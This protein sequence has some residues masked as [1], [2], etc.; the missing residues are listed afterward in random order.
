MCLWLCHV[1]YCAG[2][3]RGAGARARGARGYAALCRPYERY[4]SESDERQRSAADPD[5][6]ACMRLLRLGIR[7]EVLRM[8]L[9]VKKKELPAGAAAEAAAKSCP[10]RDARAS[11]VKH[12]IIML[13]EVKKLDRTSTLRICRFADPR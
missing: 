3:P 2:A 4:A 7:R 10:C 9:L 5:A 6:H 11:N 12:R 13:I 1:S 8:L